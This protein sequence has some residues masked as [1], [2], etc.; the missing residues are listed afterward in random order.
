M[1]NTNDYIITTLSSG[2]NEYTDLSNN[3]V[4]APFSLGSPSAINLRQTGA[5]YVVTQ[6]IPSTLFTRQII[7][8]D[9]GGGGI[10]ESIA[11]RDNLV[12][13]WKLDEGSDTTAADYGLSSGSE[14]ST[15]MTLSGVTTDVAGPSENGTP[16]A[17]SFDGVND[18]AFAPLI[19]SGGTNT[20][21]GDLFDQSHGNGMTLSMWVKDDESSRSNYNV[22]WIGTTSNSWT[23][24]MGSYFLVGTTLF[25]WMNPNYSGYRADKIDTLPHS[26]WRNIIMTYPDTSTSRYYKLY[27]D[28]V[29]VDS[30]GLWGAG[31][32]PAGVGPSTLINSVADA[33]FSIASYVR[34][35]GTSTYHSN[36]STSDIRLYNKVL[37]TDEISDIA[38]GDWT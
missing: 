33:K 15:A 35:N 11:A 6:G 25:A 21:I 20:T 5:P 27:Y 14:G 34:P 19:D 8:A 2:S 17:I 31:T 1:S 16:G 7:A 23:D 29:E 28:G 3:Q 10:P 37:T 12:H 36:I 38:A 26:G 30:Y 32:P 18:T 9:S 4:Q 22:Y 13:W 24:G